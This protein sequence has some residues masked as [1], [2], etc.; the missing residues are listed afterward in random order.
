M[1]RE[2]CA[3]ISSKIENEAQIAQLEKLWHQQNRDKI[4]EKLRARHDETIRLEQM[5]GI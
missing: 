2:G 1:D 5:S 4:R 3:L